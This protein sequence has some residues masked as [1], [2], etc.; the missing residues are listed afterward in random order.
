M[1]P[2]RALTFLDL[3]PI[4]CFVINSSWLT[5]FARVSSLSSSLLRISIVTTLG[6]AI[7]E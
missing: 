4:T 1:A 6:L 3:V 7:L 5:I 2:R